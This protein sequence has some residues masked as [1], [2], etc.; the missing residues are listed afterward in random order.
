MWNTQP[1]SP[2][3]S[4]FGTAAWSPSAVECTGGPDPNYTNPRTGSHIRG[5]CSFYSNCGA[6]VQATK[7][8]PPAQLIHHPTF[9]TVPRFSPQPQQPIAIAPVTHP[10]PAQT[11]PY[12]YQPM[13]PMYSPMP[14][15]LTVPESRDTNESIWII[16]LKELLRAGL[17]SLGHALAHFF[18]T[19]PFKKRPPE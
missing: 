16:L 4:C 2:P 9:S 12:G 1:E 13:I 18:D 15:Y 10:Q 5:R 19:T 14:S 17:K 3:P 8:I 11:A 7:L 6:K